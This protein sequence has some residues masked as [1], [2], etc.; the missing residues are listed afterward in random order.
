MA[1]SDIKKYSVY[2]GRI[3]QQQAKYAVGKGAPSVTNSPFNAIAASASQHTYNI[4]V[5]SQQTFVDRAID[6]SSYVLLQAN[7]ENSTAAPLAS[8]PTV[9]AAPG[10]DFALAAFPLHQLVSTMTATINDT[11]VTINTDSVL[12]E[13]LRLTDY[14]KN[15]SVRTCPTML[16]RYRSYNDAFLSVN[17]PLASYSDMVGVGEQ[18]NGAWGQ[19]NFTDPDGKDLPQGQ[20]YV[21][22]TGN[23]AIS[24][25][26][27]TSGGYSVLYQVVNGRGFPVITPSDIGSATFVPALPSGLTWATATKFPIF[28]K[29][30]S[31]EK[32]VLSPFVFADSSE[33]DTGLFG[34]N[35]IQIVCNLK[36]DISRVI[37]TTTGAFNG[38]AGINAV[39][40]N[41]SSPF[42]LPKLNIQFLNPSQEL[43]L[44]AK[45]IVPFMEFPRYISN[46]NA[47]LT[48]NTT[49]QQIQSQNYVLPQIPDMVLIYVKPQSYA[50]T[51]GDWYVPIS[52]ISV[53]FDNFAGLLSS[54][55]QQELYRM[56]VHNGLEMSYTEWSGLAYAA[57]GV[58]ANATPQAVQTV[59]GPLILKMGQDIALQAGQAPGLIGNF[60][61]QFNLQVDNL[62]AADIANP[63]LYVITVNSGFFE[64]L[65]G[66]SR[67]IKGVLSEADIISAEA[68]PEMTS[69]GLARVVGG[70]F[71]DK[72]GSF[73]TKAK[74]VYHQTKPIVSGIKQMM[75]DG[76]VK[77]TM[78]MLG[79][80]AAAGAGLAGASKPSKKSLSSRLM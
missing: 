24:Y 55:T 21:N 7:V 5:P 53:N 6:W 33:F 31:T 43:P 35:N 36:S 46:Q 65:A 44:P 16:D 45:S 50:A 15:R 22:G 52:G 25:G 54:H 71:L 64:T 69:D 9:V 58:L 34:I 48:A 67:I 51:E 23:T 20:I 17:S 4:N 19:L 66:S 75:P 13:V 2:D 18:P 57:S 60:N 29:F 41:G 27:Y 12:N 11:N 42:Q 32:L 40:F 30:F 1:T 78:G 38:G 47:T 70:G 73:L 62:S 63:S 26:I 59:G 72:L 8:A 74:D 79:Y 14:K 37:R 80:G 3:C 77:D 61:L 56:S 49:R 68:I 39:A 10:R 28:L 76:K